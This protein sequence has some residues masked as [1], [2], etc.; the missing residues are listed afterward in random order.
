[1]RAASESR[2]V[3]RRQWLKAVSA[4]TFAA[5]LAV[6]CAAR[7]ARRAAEPPRHFTPVRVSRE[8]VIRTVVGLRP[9]RPS[10]FVL[11]A[12]R[13]GDKVLVHNFGHGGAGVTLS[14]GTAQMAIE[15]AEAAGAN[16]RE[17]AVLGCGAIGLATARLMQR[18]G[19]RVTIY[20]RDLPPATT[21]NV[22][23]AQFGAYSVA[24]RDRRTPAFET[25]FERAVRLSHRTFQELVGGG[26]GVR[27]IENYSLSSARPAG[28]PGPL[29]DL[30]IDSR[31]LA[32][33]EHPFAYP[34]VVRFVTM[35]IEP[36]IY[37]NALVRDV[38]IAGGRIV[39]REFAD[40]AAILALPEPI[41]MNCT[42]LGAKMLF[43]DPELTPAKGQLTV[44]LPQ[45][46]VDYIVLAENNLYMF[47]RADG[48][49][50]GGTFER[51]AWSLEPNLEAMERV[52]AGHR[53]LFAKMGSRGK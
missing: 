49:L 7:G 11:R 6:G 27:W 19:W 40:P 1:M 9:Y 5:G 32:P 38:L 42:G 18:R 33:A 24:D 37:L 53:A 3:D 26:Y 23:G 39:V 16:T 31:A 22:A 14:W 34:F 25:T 29:D 21:S 52:L 43:N 10:G 46:E 8:R 41:V 51:D 35:L 48:I 30:L 13:A 15:Q 50:L 36:P 28:D 44:L 12:E 20:A 4:P 47:P 17:C 2:R 45:P